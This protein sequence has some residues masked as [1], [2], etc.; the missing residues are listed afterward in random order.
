ME[1]TEAQQVREQIEAARSEPHVEFGW[2][3]MSNITT[4]FHFLTLSRDKPPISLSPAD[5]VVKVKIVEVL[6]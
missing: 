2:I 1:K 3:M 4:N 5:Q 6:E